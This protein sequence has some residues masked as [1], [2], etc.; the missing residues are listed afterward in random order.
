METSYS[1]DFGH[2][3]RGDLESQ[4]W[5]DD[6]RVTR[7][8]GCNLRA[9]LADLVQVA[10]AVYY[11]DRRSRRIRSPLTFTGQRFLHVR[12]P[13]REPDA[14]SSAK[15]TDRLTALLY[16]FTEDQWSFEFVKSGEACQPPAEAFLFE[17]PV[18]HPNI[19]SL[20]S[21]GLDSLAG[22]CTEME[23]HPELSFVLVSG[24]TNNRLARVQRDLVRVLAKRWN[25]QS[26]EI[27]SIIV[28]FGINKLPKADEEKSQ[29]SRGF[30]FLSLGA[31]VAAMAGSSTLAVCENGIGSLNLPLNEGQLG[32][33]NARGVHPLSLVRMSQFLS[34]VMEEPV[35]IVNPFQFWTKGQMCQVLKKPDLET[36]VNMT[37]SCDGFPSRVPNSPRQCGICSSCLLRRCAM[38]AS[39]LGSNDGGSDYRHDVTNSAEVLDERQRYPLMAM[40]TQVNTIEASLASSAPWDRLIESFPELAETQMEMAESSGATMSEVADSFL[41]LYRAYVKE[42][43]GFVKSASSFNVLRGP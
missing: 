16:W 20:F 12:V 19:T 33:D 39:G 11:A 30:V 7:S 34:L 14:W 43:E 8:F 38:H 2:Y 17:S 23:K 27:R 21:G 18:A 35:H 42:W 28:P 4:Y 5:V 10:L 9:R 41:G 36:L 31:V 3:G 24:C 25:S 32:V 37:V 6:S 13:L 26:R 40:L 1:F 22:I 15:V 29:R